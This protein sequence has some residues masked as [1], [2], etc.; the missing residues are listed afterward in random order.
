MMILHVPQQ[1]KICSWIQL[2]DKLHLVTPKGY[3]KTRRIC[4]CVPIE[5]RILHDGT[6]RYLNKIF[7]VIGTK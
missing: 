4:N 3:P 2:E 5:N 6:K 7:F 1:K